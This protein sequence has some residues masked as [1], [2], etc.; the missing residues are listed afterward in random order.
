APVTTTEAPVTTTEAPVTTTEAPPT[1]TEAPPTTTEA[2]PTTTGD[3][4]DCEEADRRCSES[5]PGSYCMRYKLPSVCW[6]SNE[7]CTCDAGSSTTQPVTG[8]TCYEEDLRCASLK[9]GSY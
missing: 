3:S 7:L 9:D 8:G 4:S 6:G 5:Y 2:P 1:T